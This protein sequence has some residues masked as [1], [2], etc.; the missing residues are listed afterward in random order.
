MNKTFWK[1][2]IKTILTILAI[3]IVLLIAYKKI[4]I[5]FMKNWSNQTAQ[6]KTQKTLIKKYKTALESRD[7]L[8]EEFSSL[9]QKIQAKLPSE[10]E[11]SQFLN[12]IGKVASQTSVHIATMNPLPLKE[13]GS[14]KELS[15]EINL[16]TNLGNLV[17]FLHQMRE[18]SVVLVAN[19]L[20][21]EPKEKRSALLKGKLVISTI[22]LK[23]K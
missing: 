14:F 10:R 6:I 15:V 20:N 22:F 4:I 19:H 11:E 16:E 18:S 9:S 8:N 17:R 3:V 13:L 7:I 23:E 21:L 12:E 2:N 5:P 1:K